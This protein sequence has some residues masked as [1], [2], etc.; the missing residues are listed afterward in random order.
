MELMKLLIIKILFY[1]I[2]GVFCYRGFK[3]LNP[4]SK[5]RFDTKTLIGLVY[6]ITAIAMLF[7]GDW[8]PMFIGAF[9]ALLARLCFALDVIIK[10]K[11][12]RGI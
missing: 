3:E 7:T 5:L 1:V 9:I 6:I 4:L 10:K 12:N 2:A 8:I 11:D